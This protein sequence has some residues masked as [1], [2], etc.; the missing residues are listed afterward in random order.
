MTNINRTKESIQN[1]L[2]F[3]TDAIAIVLSYYVAG[4]IWLG[5]YW[6]MNNRQIFSELNNNCV[7][8][9]VAT[10][11]TAVFYNVKNDFISRGY[12]EE[13]RSVACKSALFAAILA[14]YELLRRDAEGIQRGIYIVTVIV[15]I[16]I[17]YISRQ[18]VKIRLNKLS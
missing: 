8:I 17:M 4:I 13:F 7:S 5:L 6:E 3:F 16:V 10:V 11:I 14:V 2:I 12:F 18:L 15:A 1:I 9:L